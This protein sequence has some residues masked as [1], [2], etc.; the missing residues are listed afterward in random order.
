MLT[1][2]NIGLALE[3]DE[4]KGFSRTI[5]EIEWLLLGL[6]L[7][8]LLAGGPADEGRVAIHT[9]LFF[10]AA[11]ILGL[12]YVHFY[13]LENRS[14]LMFETWVMIV[15][16]TWV[17]WFSGQIY[18]PLLNLYLLPII[19]SAL[20]FGKLP[21]AFK[22]GAIIACFMFL[23]YNPKSK[24]LLALPLWGEILAISA[25]M[26]LVAYITTML[27][28][29]I[30]FAMD[31]IKQVSDTDE[32]TGAYNMRAFSSVL[33]RAFRQAVRYGHALSVVMIDSDNLKQIND[34]H[35]HESGNRLLQHVVRC[36]REQ[37]RG[38]DVMARFGGDE[39]VVLLPETN[40][41]GALEIAQRIR[42]S[43]EISRFDV[44]SGHASITVSLGIASYPED[45][46]NLEVILDKADKAMY[47]AKQRGRN[48][49]VAYTEDEAS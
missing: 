37:L 47:R 10:F 2:T 42:K 40:L 9:A 20:I 19:A 25:P 26:I 48:Q 4:L 45:G 8:Y 49:V 39:F 27:A 7:V 5:A 15:F 23:A 38:S 14:K 35:G 36:I 22:L 21:T 34:T 41:K 12:H 1:R 46:G 3:E 13:K 31:K 30:R 16:I 29:D 28:A 6:V 24:T 18:S 44:R 17:V 43:V 11:F 32:L 33:Q